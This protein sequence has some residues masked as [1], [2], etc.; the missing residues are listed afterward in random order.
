VVD[1]N[2]KKS[3]EIVETMGSFWELNKSFWRQKRRCCNL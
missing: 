2:I 3:A 1:A